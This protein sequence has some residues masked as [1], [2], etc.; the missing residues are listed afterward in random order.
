MLKLKN[1]AVR[2]EFEK[3]VFRVSG[4]PTAWFSMRR[5]MYNIKATVLW[6]HDEDDEVTPWADAL[7]VKTDNHPNIKFVVTKGLGH[8]KIYH[9][10][11]VKTRLIKFIL[12]G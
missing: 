5:A 3:I 9:D 6:I 8:R 10:D 1:E 4:K 11:D 2:N 12:K 7:K